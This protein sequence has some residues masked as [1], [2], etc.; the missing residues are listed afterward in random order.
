M[1]F[2]IKLI[3]LHPFVRS[4]IYYYIF[5]VILKIIRGIFRGFR[6]SHSTAN[7]Y[8]TIKTRKK[9]RLSCNQQVIVVLVVSSLFVYPFWPVS[10]RRMCGGF[11]D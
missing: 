8:D 10:I 6:Q 7:H 3:D 1:I 11:F 9:H 5:E 2:V 4:L